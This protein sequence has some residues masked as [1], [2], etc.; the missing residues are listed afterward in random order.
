MASK[1]A[2]VFANGQIYHI[3]NR[4]I[5][6][7]ITFTGKREYERVIDTFWYYRHARLPMTL[8]AYY[9]LPTATRD[10]VTK[11]LDNDLHH[12]I[13]ILAYCLMP[14]H[15]HLLVR[16]NEE[17][18]IQ[19]TLANIS[20]S[21]TKYFNTKHQRNGP[22]FQGTFKAVLVESEEQLMHVSRYIHLN[23]V[24]SFLIDASNMM[25]Y[26][27]SSF[28]E[29]ATQ[30]KRKIC[31]IEP[32]L[33]LFRSRKSYWDFVHDQADYA[34]KLANIKHLAMDLT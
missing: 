30:V 27:W 34:K 9:A 15:F 18:G 24:S 28:I 19:K 31:D 6:R 3:F 10:A 33:G 8:S 20:N 16:Q 5:E 17:F 4:G 13:S 21:Y 2:L 14:N 7:R 23:P 32:I 25:N 11:Q 29:Y 22:L 12:A 26:P 1:R